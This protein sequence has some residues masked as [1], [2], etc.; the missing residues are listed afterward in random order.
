MEQEQLDKLS[1]EARTQAKKMTPG[2][3]LKVANQVRAI[4][5]LCCNSCKTIMRSRPEKINNISDFCP[6]CQDNKLVRNCFKRL[7]VINNG[8]TGTD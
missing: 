4:Y 3:F 1:P 7:E 2:Q 8:I 5:N 6:A